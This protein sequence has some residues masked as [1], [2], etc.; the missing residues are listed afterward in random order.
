MEKEPPGELLGDRAPS[1]GLLAG[2][3]VQDVLADRP[4][5]AADVDPFML[6][7]AGILGGQDGFF[8]DFRDLLIGNDDPFLRADLLDDLPVV[9]IYGRQNARLIFFESADVR[10]RFF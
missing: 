3:N 4:Q 6:E 1:L 2:E 9:G 10:G 5:D 7:K 8:E